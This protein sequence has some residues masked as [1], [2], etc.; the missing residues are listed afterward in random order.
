MD[1][2]IPSLRRRLK[3]WESRIT[4]G[5]K[6][7]SSN[8]CC[9]CLRSVAGTMSRIRRRRSAHR[10]GK[11]DA[12]LDGLPEADLVGQDAPLDSGERKA[13]R[14]ASTW[15]GLRSTRAL[16]MERERLSM[17]SDDALSVS[18]CAQY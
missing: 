5:R 4:E 13:N 10:L 18:K 3:V 6:N 14:A 8:S 1:W 17:L 7:F 9:H 16:A 15:W 12:R 11:D 2:L